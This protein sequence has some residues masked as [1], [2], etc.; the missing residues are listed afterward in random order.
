MTIKKERNIKVISQ[1]ANGYRP[2]PTIMLKGRWLEKFGFRI[3]TPVTV[4]CKDGELVITKREIKTY[5]SPMDIL[6][7]GVEECTR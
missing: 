1:N 7:A 6:M 2:T 5:T 3:D 4:T